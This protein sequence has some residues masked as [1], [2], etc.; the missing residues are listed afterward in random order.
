M[1]PDGMERRRELR[2]SVGAHVLL[3]KSNGEC[4]ATTAVNVSASGALLDLEKP[5]QLSVGEE[6]TLELDLPQGIP[7]SLSTWGVARIV[8]ADGQ[9]CGVQLVAGTFVPDEIPRE[10]SNSRNEFDQNYR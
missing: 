2:F 7:K 1:K 10:M 5:L 3:R 6:I 4:Y 9:R 8:H